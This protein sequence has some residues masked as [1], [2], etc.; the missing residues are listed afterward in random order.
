MACICDPGGVEVSQCDYTPNRPPA[1]HKPPA[2]PRAGTRRLHGWRTQTRPML[3]R[4]PGGPDSRLGQDV[5]AALLVQ[6]SL[7]LERGDLVRTEG[8]GRDFPQPHSVMRRWRVCVTSATGRRAV[9]RDLLNRGIVERQ[10]KGSVAQ[11]RLSL[12]WGWDGNVAAYHA[13]TR[14]IEARRHALG[15]E[16]NPAAPKDRRRYIM[17]NGGPACIRLSCVGH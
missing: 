10:G 17:E 14:E 16:A 3:C 15:L 11:W 7:A 1:P 8:V 9:M 4:L 6:P 12:K 13:A 5:G 2:T